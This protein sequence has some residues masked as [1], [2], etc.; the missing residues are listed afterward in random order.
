MKNLFLL[1]VLVTLALSSCSK[2]DSPAAP[3]AAQTS[4]FLDSYNGTYTGT[5]GNFPLQSD[6][7][8]KLTK[9]G[10]GT[11]TLESAV[12]GNKSIVGL[13]ASSGGGFEGKLSDGSNVSILL[14]GNQLGIACPGYAFS[15][16][17]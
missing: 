14:S 11:C 6:I 17:K 3:A 7:I 16:A 1:F 12:L 9:T 5:D 10:C 8:V 15:G 4:C 2:S 13:T